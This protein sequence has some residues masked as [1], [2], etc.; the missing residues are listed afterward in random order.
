MWRTSFLL[1]VILGF[2]TSKLEAQQDQ[3]WVYD[4]KGKADI[5]DKLSEN[6]TDSL[7]WSKYYGKSWDEMNAKDLEK[8]SIWKQQLMLQKLAENKAI[9]GFN[10]ANEEDFFIDEQAF[11]EYQK[12]IDEAAQNNAA[13]ETISFADIK[14]L[15]AVIV[16][17]REGMEDLKQNIKQ[18]FIILEDMY[19]DMFQENGLEYT[20]Y[21]EKYPDESYSQNKWVEEHDALLNKHRQKQIE[22]IKKKYKLKDE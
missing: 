11:K 22:E 10:M 16:P 21:I 17:V 2:L 7:L 6:P 1:F 5:W 8:V 19:N 15:E 20:Y 14:G 18:N 4:P 3:G 9:V 13:P 12:L